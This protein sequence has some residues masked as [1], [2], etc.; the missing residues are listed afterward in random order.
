[1]TTETGPMSPERAQLIART[2]TSQS[3]NTGIMEGYVAAGV[4]E[5]EWV[6]AGIARTTARIQHVL[7][8]GKKTKVGVP[9]K[10]PDGTLMMHPGDPNAPVKHLANCRCSTIPTKRSLRQ[11]LRRAS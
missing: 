3:E 10:L 7:M 9:F 1:M 8:D 6:H 2:E 4:T 5:I 11:A